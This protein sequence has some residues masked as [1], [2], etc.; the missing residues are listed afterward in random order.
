MPKNQQ[1]SI[2]CKTREENGAAALSSYLEQLAI[3]SQSDT[4]KNI[5]VTLTGVYD[6]RGLRA[7][8]YK[9]DEALKALSGNTTANTKKKTSG[10]QASLCDAYK[11]LEAMLND[12][13][14]QYG[15]ISIDTAD[16]KSMFVK[17][18]YSL[19]ACIEVLMGMVEYAMA[20][21]LHAANV[22]SVA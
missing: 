2:V 9:L 3:I 17:G 8:T 10:E 20:N 18:H 13:D 15:M 11:L 6:H 16:K 21:N 14:L 19:K 12:T 5:E 7:G 4:L 1:L 22:M